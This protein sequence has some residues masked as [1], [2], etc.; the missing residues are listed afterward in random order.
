M[1]RRLKLK[2][3]ADALGVSKHFLRTKAIA[4]EIP[5]IRAGNR[6]IFDIE[7][8][9]SIL[10]RES[11]KNLKTEENISENNQYGKLRKIY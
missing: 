2:E 1:S 3:A 6:Y 9:E 5:Y 8:V 4:G 10:T 11:L 7:Q